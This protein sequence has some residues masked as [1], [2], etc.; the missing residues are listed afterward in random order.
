LLRSGFVFLFHGA[1][2]A[3]GR[4]VVHRKAQH[5][6]TACAIMQRH[7][8]G[9]AGSMDKTRCWAA[10]ET[11]VGKWLDGEKLLKTQAG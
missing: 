9:L 7:W 3:V 2:N 11:R 8:A 10:S 5:R 1:L 6:Y 4:T